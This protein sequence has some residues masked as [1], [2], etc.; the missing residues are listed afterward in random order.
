[1]LKNTSVSAI[2]PSRVVVLGGG[3]F[4]GG[5]I[6]NRFVMGGVFVESIGRATF[7]LLAVETEIKLVEYLRPDDT[8]IFVAA[9]APC[10]N[11]T[12]LIENLRMTEV[13]ISALKSQKIKHLIYISSDAVYRDS[14][15]P[16]SEY[17][18]A[19]PSSV[20]GSMHLAREVALKNELDIP[21]T[22]IRPTLVYGLKDPHNGYGPN[23][24]RRLALK[25]EDIVL[26]GEGEELRDHVFID[27]VAELVYLASRSKSL[28]IIN[29]VSGEIVSFRQLAEY[30]T[31]KY[32]SH[33]AIK[34]IPRHG[35]IPH[36]GYREFT[37]SVASKLFPGFEFR[38]WSKGLD[39]LRRSQLSNYS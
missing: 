26:F 28:G 16:I 12:G 11:I 31:Q 2:D 34:S 39:D 9:K 18:C 7:D 8:L 38:S 37:T 21:L 6:K 22:I 27:D 3:G 17:S 23:S 4:I 13:V 35:E 32:K 14:D 20:H 15:H 25:N 19:E 10:R 5:A 36:N 30:L 33:G 24:F 1:M 29:A